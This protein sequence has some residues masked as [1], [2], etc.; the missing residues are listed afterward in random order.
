MVETKPKEFLSA[1]LPTTGEGNITL[2]DIDRTAEKHGLSR[3]T[4]VVK[5][6]ELMTKFDMFFMD[7]AANKAMELQLPIWLVIQNIFIKQ[8][9]QDAAKI[10]VYGPN[11]NRPLEEFMF[12]EKGILTG[13]QLFDKLKELY[14]AQLKATGK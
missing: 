10:E 8:L 3:A 14:V 7:N 13:E 4:F 12:T 5:A 11:P 1:K 2:A 6:T 9:A